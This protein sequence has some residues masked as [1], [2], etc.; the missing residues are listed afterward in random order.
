METE[1]QLK[2]MDGTTGAE[3]LFLFGD[4]YL[5]KSDVEEM[6][7]RLAAT[8]RKLAQFN[9]ALKPIVHTWTYEFGYTHYDNTPTV[10]R[11]NNKY[12]EAP[13]VQS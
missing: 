4:G 5:S 12:E 6:R 11:I 3:Y 13:H 1:A 7:E 9:K 2:A 10:W 8:P